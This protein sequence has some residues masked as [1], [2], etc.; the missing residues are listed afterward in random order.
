MPIKI[1][2]VADCYQ[3]L[4]SGDIE[5]NGLVEIRFKL[6][7]PQIYLES[8][9]V[10]KSFAGALRKYK[11]TLR[12]GAERS[13][14]IRLWKNTES[15]SIR[16]L[17]SDASFE[18][19]YFKLVKFPAIVTIWI[20]W[21]RLQHF[22]QTF[23]KDPCLIWRTYN[24][25][26]DT[27]LG[28]SNYQSWLRKNELSFPND[29]QVCT[30]FRKKLNL[31]VYPGK[32]PDFSPP[33][34]SS[35]VFGNVFDLSSEFSQ[36]YE[37]LN[38]II[39][40]DHSGLKHYFLFVSTDDKIA[41]GG[42]ETIVATLQNTN[43][44][45][46]YTD[47]DRLIG[48][49][50]DRPEFKPEWNPEYFIDSNYTGRAVVFASRHI[51]HLDLKNFLPTLTSVGNILHNAITENASIEIKHI[52]SICLHRCPEAAIQRY[53]PLGKEP[54]HNL[55]SNSDQP[56]VDILI[57]TRD[58]LEILYP[59]IRSILDKSTYKNF[60][61][62]ILDNNSQEAETLKF[63]EKIETHPKVKVL[64]YPH[65]FNYSAINNFGANQSDSDILV[66]LNNDI[67]VINPDWLEALVTQAM[68]P[69]IGCVGAKLYYPNGWIQH[70]GVILGI[71]DVA[72]H[73][74][75]FYPG[76]SRG[77]MNRLI[78]TQR[79]SAVTAAC[80]AIR[81]TIWD[82]VNGLDEENLTVAYNDVDF[83]LRVLE[84]GYHNIWTPKAELVHHES[85]SR[86]H[87]DTPE[88]KRRY[89]K[90]VKYMKQRWKDQLNLD[91]YY[92]PALSHNKED[93]S[94]K[95]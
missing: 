1:A 6:S 95:S 73:S 83:C 88:K 82:Q 56:S 27:R 46:I 52:P 69:H 31:V 37:E 8:E 59:C 66:L 68:R 70:A 58:K 3:L 85:I 63:F 78:S 21:K 54:L 62:S 40:N 44:E 15:I 61:I 93:F 77:Y 79:V 20:I 39:Q 87:D 4:G 53:L 13:R 91:P 90:E 55:H 80:L 2:S 92:H 84:A 45:I 64:K 86:G 76:D 38:K 14:I 60:K 36:K 42:A 12:P 22:K 35:N 75:R 89:Q 72:G 50:R 19:E 49:K 32:K 67:E 43:A 29:L 7:R 25:T 5:H 34:N 17:R 41:A 74:H 11:I 18:L 16:A 28:I 51:K 81:K 10:V 33:P 48:D 71:G 9:I 47:E 65:P 23:P 57:P 24:Q 30:S 94:L 26:F